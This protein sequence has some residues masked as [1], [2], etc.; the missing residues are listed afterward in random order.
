[1]FPF[2]R[3]DT[4]LR[5]CNTLGPPGRRA[6]LAGSPGSMPAYGEEQEH[7]EMALKT[8]RKELGRKKKKKTDRTIFHWKWPFQ[9][10][11]WWFSLTLQG[12]QQSTV[13]FLAVSPSP[14]SLLSPAVIKITGWKKLQASQTGIVSSEALTATDPAPGLTEVQGHNRILQQELLGRSDS[15]VSEH[16]LNIPSDASFWKPSSEKF[17]VFVILSLK[18]KKKSKN[19][20]W[21]EFQKWLLILFLLFIYLFIG[22][23]FQRM[24]SV[25]AD[26]KVSLKICFH[27]KPS[28][29]S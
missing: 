13:C 4:S 18:K 26:S 9:Q 1:M 6:G 28:L 20:F 11:G 27:F 3:G 14:F 7:R 21:R 23:I 15:W 24:D 19:P 17:D 16:E 22:W 8:H 25:D 29:H 5:I 10:K 2:S 12:L